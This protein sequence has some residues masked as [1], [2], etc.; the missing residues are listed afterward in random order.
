MNNSLASGSSRCIP[1]RVC[2]RSLHRKGCWFILRSGG[3][4]SQDIWQRPP[5]R[6]RPGGHAARPARGI[7]EL[8]L[9]VTYDHGYVSQ[10][11][12]IGLDS[13]YDIV[14]HDLRSSPDDHQ[15][16]AGPARGSDGRAYRQPPSAPNRDK[17]CG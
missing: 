13:G 15:C 9:P 12:D 1:L 3:I 5:S 7:L 4:I 2:W 14:R 16:R 17:M 8:L 6:A 11:Y 10:T